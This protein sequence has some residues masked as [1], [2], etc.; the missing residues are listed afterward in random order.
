M[1]CEG[2]FNNVLENMRF[3]HVCDMDGSWC[4][5]PT[6]VLYL[7]LV[8]RYKLSK[9]PALGNSNCTKC[10]AK[11]QLVLLMLNL[12]ILSVPVFLFSN[13]TLFIVNF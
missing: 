7:I 8:R 1:A 11:C 10:N 13:A 3:S 6:K 4:N 9:Y 2:I 5:N 12:L